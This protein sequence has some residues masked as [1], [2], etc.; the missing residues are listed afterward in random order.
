M[1]F[2]LFAAIAVLIRLFHKLAG[3]REDRIAFGF[4]VNG[5]SVVLF[6]WII[7]GLSEREA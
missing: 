4:C 3:L 6:N 5:E 1:L 2:F 7:S